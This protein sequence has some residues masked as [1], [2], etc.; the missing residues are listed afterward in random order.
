MISIVLD[1][2]YPWCITTMNRGVWY[3]VYFT[4]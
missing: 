4:W 3:Q 2:L 1:Y